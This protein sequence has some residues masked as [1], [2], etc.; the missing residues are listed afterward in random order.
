MNRHF[1]RGD[2]HAA[3]KHTKRCSTSPI[4]RAMQI[5]TITRRYFMP[6]GV[7]TIKS[8]GHVGEDGE[9]LEPSRTADRNAT[10]RGCCGKQVVVSRK[11]KSK[12]HM[13][14]HFRAHPQSNWK[15][16]SEERLRPPC[17][18]VV[19]NQE[20][21]QVPT[22]RRMDEPTGGHTCNG[23]SWMNVEDT[24]SEARWAQRPPVRDDSPSVR[25]LAKI[26]AA[27]K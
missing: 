9:K 4:V 15:Q 8:R 6:I 26:K 17:S 25:R 18:V 3:N 23:H 7:A 24:L 5:T 21:T 10:W 19:A 14:S 20:A 13:V 27:G 11:V 16:V 1:S 12:F 22:G 2:V